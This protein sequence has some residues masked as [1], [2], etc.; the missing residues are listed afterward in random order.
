MV[1]AFTTTVVSLDVVMPCFF[2]YMSVYDKTR[3]E[4]RTNVRRV[5][6]AEARVKDVAVLPGRR[7]TRTAVFAPSRLEMH[8]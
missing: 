5:R 4:S 1:V 6:N 3:F 7:R 8:D 2:M